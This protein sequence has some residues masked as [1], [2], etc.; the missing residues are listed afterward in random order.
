M[1]ERLVLS[2]AEAAEA[3]GVSE[4][5]VYELTDR[6]ELPCLRFG[7]RKVI[8]RRGIELLVESAIADF[9]PG[10]VLTSLNGATEQITR[11]RTDAT[12]STPHANDAMPPPVQVGD[13]AVAVGNRRAPR[14][15][16]GAPSR[17]VAARDRVN[18]EG[19]AAPLRLFDDGD[20]DA[21][22]PRRDHIAGSPTWP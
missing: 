4:D 18:G 20:R 3:L 8:P 9:D 17:P 12:L 16:S 15:R 10:A 19:D 2:V 13:A 5:L 14:L 7:R 11:G 22:D 6:G 1:S 21:N